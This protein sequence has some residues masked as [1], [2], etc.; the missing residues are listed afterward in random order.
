MIDR[1][2]GRLA[3]DGREHCDQAARRIEPPDLDSWTPVDAPWARKQPA[4]VKPEN[5][6]DA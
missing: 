3:H 5:E 2:Y 1:H 6:R 4:G